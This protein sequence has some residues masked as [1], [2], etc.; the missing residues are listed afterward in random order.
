MASL[1]KVTLIGRL[2]RDPEII[3]FENGGH[4][5]NMTLATTDSYRDRDNNW[6]ESTEWH[7]IVVFGMLANDI[8]EK[9][10][11]YSKG[12]LMYVEGRIKSR[13]YV[14][15][16]NTTRSITEIVVD[17]MMQLVPA[18]P[19]S[20]SSA[21]APTQSSTNP[22]YRQEASPALPDP[23]SQQFSS[24]NISTEGTDTDDLPF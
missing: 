14:D 4:K 3:T 22:A 12:D 1:N 11:N 17:R 20:M 6:I 21:T 24:I 19:R 7:N 15:K 18:Q 23:M 5:A 13:Q 16:D 10:R 2:G 8:F 9:R